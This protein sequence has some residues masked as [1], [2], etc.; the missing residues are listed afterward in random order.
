MA[1][2]NL[3]RARVWNADEWRQEQ[4][5]LHVNE[6]QGRQ[7]DTYGLHYEARAQSRVPRFSEIEG[8]IEASRS[9]LDLSQG[10]DDEDARQIAKSTW[11][12]ACEVLR[13]AARTAYRRYCYALPAPKIG[14][15]ADGSIDLY[16]GTA[17]F[18]LLINVR[19]S[20]EAPSD[21]YGERA[22][23]KV[24]GPFD[25]TSPKFDFLGL[26]VEQ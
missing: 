23:S 25:P 10:W 19:E 5:P 20:G 22:G 1:R 4:Q 9:M 18:T 13:D 24:Q 21:F 14:P 15:C 16:W 8:A 6:W 11:D 2:S 26:L 3:A 7:P 17:D 12:L